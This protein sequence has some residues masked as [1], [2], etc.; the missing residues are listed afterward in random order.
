MLLSTNL[1]QIAILDPTIGFV[2]AAEKYLFKVSQDKFY[3]GKSFLIFFC[4]SIDIH[5]EILLFGYQQTSMSRF[6]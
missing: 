3:K 4:I 6:I 2:F 5:T 1:M